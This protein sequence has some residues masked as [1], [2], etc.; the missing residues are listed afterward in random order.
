[1][2]EAAA[3][4]S[5]FGGLAACSAHI[6]SILSW[7]VSRGEGRT[8]ALSAL[9]FDEMRMRHPVRPGDSLTCRMQYLSKRESRT[10]VDRGVVRYRGS[11]VNQ[12]G[13][14]VFSLVVTSLVARRPRLRT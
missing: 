9:A 1:M 8:A 11:L 12:E 5:V 14:V 10:K 7:F 6:F 4:Q 2:D 3:A 13:T